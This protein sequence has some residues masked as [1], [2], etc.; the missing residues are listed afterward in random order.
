MCVKAE[1]NNLAWYIRTSNELT[2]AV[3]KTELLNSEGAQENNEF[4]QDKENATLNNLSEKKCMANS[5]RKC[6]RQLIKLRPGSG[7]ER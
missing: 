2:E 7:M 1:E 5:Y 4:K 6:V 3:R